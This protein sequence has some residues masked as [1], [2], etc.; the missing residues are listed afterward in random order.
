MVVCVRRVLAIVLIAVLLVPAGSPGIG[1]AQDPS[2]GPQPEASA[3]PD[4]TPD[5]SPEPTKRPKPTP[6]PTKRPKP[7][8]EPSPDS[9]ELPV[10][11]AEPSPEPVASDPAPS[12]APVTP[13]PSRQPDASP[14]PS[15]PTASDGPGASPSPGTSVEPSTSPE[16]SVP[17]TIEPRESPDPPPP[18][19]EVVEMRTENSQTFVQEDGSF[20]TEFSTEPRFYEPKGSDLL[21]P[22][23][24]GFG[25]PSADG[26][27]VSSKAPTTVVV[28]DAGTDD[29]FLVVKEGG[30]QVSIGLPAALATQ[31][32]GTDPERLSAEG[33]GAVYDDL[34]PDGEDLLVVPRANGAQT[35]LILRERPSGNSFTFIVRLDGLTPKPLAGGAIALLDTDGRT[36]GSIRAPYA[37]DSSVVPDLGSGESTSD[38]TTRLRDKGD[39]TWALT[40]TVD[41]AFLDRAVY[42]VYLDPLV[43]LQDADVNDTFVY[44]GSPGTNYHGYARPDS[45][46]YHELWLGEK[47]GSGGKVARIFIRFWGLGELRG[48]HIDSAILRMYPYYQAASNKATWIKRVTEQWD[49]LEVT[50]ADQPGVWD[51]LGSDPASFI[52]SAGT[53]AQIEVTDTV[54]GWV[55]D[56]IPNYGFRLDPNGNDTSFWKRFI[57]KE[58]GSDDSPRLR[59]WWYR[60]VATITGP[61]DTAWTSSRTLS[62]SYNDNNGN[63]VYPQSHFQVQVATDEAFEDVAVDSTQVAG[64][65]TSWAAPDTLVTSGQDYWWRVR[66][67]DGHGWSDWAVGRWHYDL[68]P[69]TVAEIDAAKARAAALLQT[70]IADITL[71]AAYPELIPIGSSSY[72]QMLLE[73]ATSERQALV[74]V[75]KATD[76]A[77]DDVQLAALQGGPP[78]TG[79]DKMT[80]AALAQISAG[81][82]STYS[83]YITGI[84]YSGVDAQ[85]AS[86]FAGTSLGPAGEV[87]APD[88]AT[89]EAVHMTGNQ[90]TAST[91]AAGIEAFLAAADAVA[92][93]V[94]PVGMVPIVFV[95]A[96]PEDIADLADRTDVALVDGEHDF[97]LSSTGALDRAAA[98]IHVPSA[99]AND[100]DGL[101]AGRPVK[102]GVI[103]YGRTSIIVPDDD[104][105]E[106]SGS[107]DLPESKLLEVWRVQSGAD[108]FECKNKQGSPVDA[109]EVEHFTR[110]A[111]IAVGLH[112]AAPKAKFIEISSNTNTTGDRGA[113]KAMIHAV[114]CA[115]EAGSQV[116][117]M[118]ISQNVVGTA[119]M[120]NAAIDFFSDRRGVLFVV[121]AGNT[122]PER[123]TA[124]QCEPDY[125]TP[126]P[127]SAWNVLAVGGIDDTGPKDRLWL[128]P[129]GLPRH[130]WG[131]PPGPRWARSSPDRIKPDILAPAQQVDGGGYG[132]ADGTSFAAPLVAG[133]GAIVIDALPGPRPVQQLRAII[134]ASGRSHPPVGM[135][136][137]VEWAGLGVVDASLAGKIAAGFGDNGS[138][139]VGVYGCGTYTE[140]ITAPKDAKVRVVVTWNAHPDT[141]VDKNVPIRAD[142]NLTVSGG[143]G[144][145]SSA[146][147]ASNVEFVDFIAPATATYRI[148]VKQPK[149]KNG[150]D[151]EVAGLA[152]AVIPKPQ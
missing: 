31:A 102:V 53:T 59:V 86:G 11:T 90:I 140:P 87:L 27:L 40:L 148:K 72:V 100:W 21:R 152:W 131:N 93:D 7:S 60:P 36:T 49:S 57:A 133:V 147:K 63:A 16:P 41:P 96:L 1:I 126:S 13:R 48:S 58:Q 45:P 42:P 94:D 69:P 56:T 144:A 54:Q 55:S 47:P 50:W 128:D 44:S 43:I 129:A 14:D 24:A 108:G 74:A 116:V 139:L 6:E 33:E 150:C 67:K 26:T 119:A 143:G 80:E 124:T 110:V 73:S 120:M 51:L 123:P 61:T 92:T 78:L 114:R 76:V 81:G 84:D 125:M 30:E 70:T 12:D 121:S 109:D 138:D 106:N 64:S 62:W 112:G 20:I 39:G 142:L 35:F 132:P 65:G 146:R 99:V 2:P 10:P 91:T 134:L 4:P 107:S 111:A 28:K 151:T 8:A 79:V 115:V 88:L 71:V 122:R 19:T 149:Q 5:P 77:I 105:N 17:P 34:L 97:E 83:F 82:P 101:D 141:P 22:I 68:N 52:S 15:E 37:V 23:D 29:G 32:E 89:A 127:A 103:E 145:W 113:D 3:A 46:Y 25:R 95:T 104:P 135:G 75:N 85:A 38:V 137:G 18:G 136:R 9:T 118:S 66:V 98:T 117:N 130:C